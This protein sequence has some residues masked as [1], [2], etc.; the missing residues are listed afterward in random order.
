MRFQGKIS[1]WFYGIIIFAA[2]IFTPISILAAKNGK[3]LLFI[4]FLGIFVLIEAFCSCIVLRNFVE[5]NDDGLLIAF[6][7]V[8]VRIPY[9]D[10]EK[11][12]A[13]NDPSS[14]LAASFDRI[15]LQIKNGKS[16]MISLYNKQAFYREMQK[17]NADIRIV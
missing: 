10:I 4:I 7:L 9:G 13:T 16:V 1:K 12:G 6:G 15:R 8:K 14:S 2:A 5:L 17:K 3:M 11:I